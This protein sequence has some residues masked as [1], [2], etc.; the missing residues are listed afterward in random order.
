MTKNQELHAL[1]NGTGSFE[2]RAFQ[3]EDPMVAKDLVWAII[4]VEMNRGEVG[5][6]LVSVNGVDATLLRH[7]EVVNMLQSSTG[8][9]VLELQYSLPDPC[10]CR[11]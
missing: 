2:R 8:P 3:R 10:T 1:N 6:L 9:T 4:N 5:D 7:F 11:F